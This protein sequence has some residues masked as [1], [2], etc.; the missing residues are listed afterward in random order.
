MQETD[1]DN[2]VNVTKSA[3][4]SPRSDPTPTQFPVGD[5]VGIGCQVEI[6]G[7]DARSI[8]TDRPSR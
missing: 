7:A 4:S 5:R 6:T 8:S 1:D 2:T 3:A